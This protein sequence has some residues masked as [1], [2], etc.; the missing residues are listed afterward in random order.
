MKR[1]KTLISTI[2]LAITILMA[3]SLT[4]YA[5]T[6]VTHIDDNTLR[7]VTYKGKPPHKRFIVKKSNNPSLYHHYFQR[8]S[9][10][11][12]NINNHSQSHRQGAPGKY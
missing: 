9:A 2:A 11:D 1:Q 4:V 8:L 6:K 5:D 3:S 12:A 10:D 7:V